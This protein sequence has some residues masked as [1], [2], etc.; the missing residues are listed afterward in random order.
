MIPELPGKK[1]AATI[2]RTAGAIDTSSRTLLIELDMDNSKG[3]F[4]AGSYA[5]V[6]FHDVAAP[7]A[8]EVLANTLL[9][10]AEGP[11]VGIVLPDGKVELRSVTLGRDLGQMVEVIS[12]VTPEDKIIVNPSDSLVSGI[13]VRIAAP[14][15]HAKLAKN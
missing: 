9:F 10:R 2:V 11:Q 12:G 14:D 1:F 5:Q 4:I 6:S 8:M 13:Q 3:Q 15:E 7:P